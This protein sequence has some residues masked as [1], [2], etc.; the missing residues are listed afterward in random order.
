MNFSFRRVFA[1]N[2]RIF[3]LMRHSIDRSLDMLYWP[4]L[5]LFL[6]G[7]T[8]LYFHT[9]APS[10]PVVTVMVLG[11]ILWLVIIRGQYE[12]SVNVLEEIWNRNLINI[13]A[14]PLRLSEWVLATLMMGVLKA[15]V[16]FTV[17]ALIALLVF[18]VN[19][20]ML[21]WFI[22]PFMALSLMTG[23]AMGLFVSGVILRWG[24]KLQALAWT[25]I[26]V[27]SPFSAV[28]YPVSILPFWAQKI[29]AFIP[30]SYVFE[31]A[32]AVLLKGTFDPLFL[33][34]SLLLNIIYLTLAGWFF[35]TSF[36]KSLQKGL[37]KLL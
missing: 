5:D 30:T 28:Y 15:A 35:Y 36:Q 37:L 14:A 12:L 2:L 25:L 10:S 33:L 9:Y 32:R 17:G 1:L 31:S 7:I 8:S 20:F 13:F 6:W 4:L 11:V 34:V 18:K 23:W 29:S 3:Y 19:V 26:W 16:S 27:I 24:S 22:L 21:G